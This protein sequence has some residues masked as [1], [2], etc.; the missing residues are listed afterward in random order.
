MN[1][2]RKAF[3]EAVA[4]CVQYA[5]SLS[6]EQMAFAEVALEC[7]AIIRDASEEALTIEEVGDGSCQELSSF[8]VAPAI[9]Y[10]SGL[11]RK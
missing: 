5:H 2:R 4:L 9:D 6:N 1:E 3:H 11:L 10:T 7:G 8:L